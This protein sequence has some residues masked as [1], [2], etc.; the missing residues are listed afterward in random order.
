M[1]RDDGL[2]VW[3]AAVA[4]FDSVSVEDFSELIVMWEASVD[5][6]EEPLANVGANIGTVRGVE[7]D[8]VSA[9]VLT[10]RIYWGGGIEFE[11]VVVTAFL[12]SF[13]V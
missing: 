3:H 4:D 9:S 6:L 5:D 10:L 7:P 12:Q 1:R 13:L 2:H 11:L 8:D